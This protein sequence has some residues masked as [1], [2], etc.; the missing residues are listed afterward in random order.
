MINGRGAGYART[1][2]LNSYPGPRH[3][4][5]LKQELNLSPAQ[6]QKVEAIFQQMDA[7]AKPLGRKIV[8]REKQLS[9]AFAAKKAVLQKLNYVVG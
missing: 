5:D 8:E 4:L 9:R 6:V 3:V 1:A 7:E 2:K